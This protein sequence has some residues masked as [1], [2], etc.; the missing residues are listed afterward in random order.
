[1]QR[2][3]RLATRRAARLA[4]G[5]YVVEGPT[6]VLDACDAGVAVESAYVDADV[7]SDAVAAAADRLDRA[8]VGVY[9]VAG[10]VLA[11]LGGA[12]TPQGIAAVVGLG[13]TA[14]DTVLAGIDRTRVVVVLAGVADPG[15]A[16]T[17][18]RTAEAAGA[19]AVVFA[20]ESVDPFAPKVVRSSAGSVFRVP[21]A[22]EPDAGLAMQRVAALGVR[23]VGLASRS[24]TPW[25]HADLSGSLALVL[26][27]E[28]HGLP[29]P[30]EVGI[31]EWVSIPMAGRVESLNVAAAGAV[32]LFEA[33][34]Q[35]DQTTGRTRSETAGC[36]PD[37]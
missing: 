11:R 26:G 23:L 7:E 24:G 6:L 3:R 36:A 29:E 9:E 1:V 5:A 2:L 27:N 35:R 28:A 33:A 4:E 20:G 32:V 14:I 21:I 13:T 12:V 15:N 10:G 31:D 19:G 18:L 30:V 25:H 34:R 22:V 17:L 8:G 37:D 16:G